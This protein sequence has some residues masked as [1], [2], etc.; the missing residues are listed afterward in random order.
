[1]R[2]YKK[3][4]LS[5][6]F[7]SKFIH[8]NNN[9]IIQI[10]KGH[11]TLTSELSFKYNYKSLIWFFFLIFHKKPTS[12]TTKLQKNFENEKTTLSGLK[13]SFNKKS[14]WEIN[15]KLVNVVLP[16]LESFFVAK[17]SIIDNSIIIRYSDCL[18]Y[19][20]TEIIEEKKNLKFISKFRINLF[21]TFLK[22][23]KNHL[24]FFFDCNNLAIAYN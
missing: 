10:D 14:F 7:L 11:M 5:S 12:I 18:S 24:I 19:D 6:I 22:K 3:I 1:M 13:L 9:A 2:L 4:I 17:G 20:E 15:K 21:V 23:E 16:Q 8:E